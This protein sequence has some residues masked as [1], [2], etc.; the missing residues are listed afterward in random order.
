MTDKNDMD[1]CKACNAPVGWAEER[2][3][4]GLRPG[5]PVVCSLCGCVMKLNGKLETEAINDDELEEF[6]AANP[7][8]RRVHLGVVSADTTDGTCCPGCHHPVRDS[9]GINHDGGPTPG[10]LSVCG[11]CGAITIYTYDMRMR[12]ATEHERECLLSNPETPQEVKEIAARW[13]GKKGAQWD[14]N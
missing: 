3:E 2:R 1:T 6:F 9:E 4:L 8:V 12:L 11:D 5:S 14:R 13:R 10:A 7:A